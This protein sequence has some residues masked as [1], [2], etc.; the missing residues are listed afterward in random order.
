M[1]LARRDALGLTCKNGKPPPACKP[2][3]LGG[4]GGLGGSRI[5]RGGRLGGGVLPTNSLLLP[6]INF[7]SQISPPL[8]QKNLFEKRI[9]N[10]NHKSNKADPVK[11]HSA[12]LGFP[13]YIGCLLVHFALKYC[14]GQPGVL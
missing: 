9:P 10:S 3:S 7:F 5:K 4:K 6:R 1:S 2:S 8:L 12:T 13:V 11:G 14:A